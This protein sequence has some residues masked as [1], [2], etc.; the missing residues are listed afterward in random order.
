MNEL[1]YKK[2]ILIFC[3]FL[4]LSL[5]A[6]R[7]PAQTQ[8][9]L[10]FY[11]ER[12]EYGEIEVKRDTLFELRNFESESASR[13]AIPA[14]RDISEIVRA[15]AT[16]TVVFLPGEE[17]AYILLPLLE[18]KSGYVRREAAYA[19]GKTGNA[20]PVRRLLDLLETDKQQEVKTACAVALGQL[21]D[22]SAIKSLTNVIRKKRKK[23]EIFLRRA[24]ARSIG[25]IAQR[26]QTRN[27]TQTTPESFL[28]E[29]YKNVNRPK[30]RNLAKTFPVFS[31]ANK[32]LINLLKDRKEPADSRREA[33]FAL[34]EISDTAS[35]EVL[36]INSK[37]ND[38]YLAEISRESLKK[39]YAAVNPSNSDGVRN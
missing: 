19:L 11:S 2:N 18:D 21:G 8:K 24:A 26:V 27:P 39:T 30:H 7:S 31:N 20:K 33:A 5:F 38:Y 4:F 13:V 15:T 37:S 3:S 16:H 22:V 1:F 14:L 35:I 32:A 9:E 17:A 23:K 29:K 25:R 12:I 34:G 6:P 28:P 36:K 10:K